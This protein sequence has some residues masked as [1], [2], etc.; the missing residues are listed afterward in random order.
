MQW[1]PQSQA[2]YGRY[3]SVEERLL[4]SD[5]KKHWLTNC[6]QTPPQV[7]SQPHPMRQPWVQPSP[8]A[9]SYTT[10][11]QRPAAATAT[12]G[13]KQYR[14]N[15]APTLRWALNATKEAISPALS[16]ISAVVRSGSVMQDII[17]SQSNHAGGDALTSKLWPIPELVVR[18]SRLSTGDSMRHMLFCRCPSPSFTGVDD[19]DVNSADPR[20][21]VEFHQFEAPFY[22][23]ASKGRVD[24]LCRSLIINGGT[25]VDLINYENTDTEGAATEWSTRQQLEGHNTMLLTSA[26]LNLFPHTASCPPAVAHPYFFIGTA[27]G[28][29]VVGKEL[30]ERAVSFDIPDLKG[31]T[32]A[33]SAAGAP[34]SG[35]VGSKG[36]TFPFYPWD[37]VTY[38]EKPKR[39][40]RLTKVTTLYGHPRGPVS[41]VVATPQ[42]D[43]LVSTAGGASGAGEVFVWDTARLML[44]RVIQLAGHSLVG[45]GPSLSYFFSDHLN[46]LPV[47]DASTSEDEAEEEL[48]PLEEIEDQPPAAPPVG[49]SDVITSEGSVAPV[50][51]GESANHEKDGKAADTL[52]SASADAI[53]AFE[54]SSSAGIEIEPRARKAITL[55]N[56]EVFTSK[57]RF[58][59]R[60]T[61]QLEL[62][63]QQ[64]Y[65]SA[66]WNSPLSDSPLLQTALS[67][68]SSLFFQPRS[69]RVV[70]AVNEATGDIVAAV[71][72]VQVVEQ[73]RPELMHGPPQL[74]H[75]LA[76]FSINGHPIAKIPADPPVHKQHKADNEVVCAPVT[77]AALTAATNGGDDK[78]H[79]ISPSH[80]PTTPNVVS[81]MNQTHRPSYELHDSI[82]A[83]LFVGNVVFAGFQDGVVG[84][85]CGKTLVPFGR[86]P[87]DNGEATNV[88]AVANAI[89]IGGVGGIGNT[90]NDPAARSGVNFASANCDP[91][92]SNMTDLA[93]SLAGGSGLSMLENVMPLPNVTGTTT[94][95]SGTQQGVGGVS[96]GA[97]GAGGGQHQQSKQHQGMD[98]VCP[99]VT[100]LSLNPWGTALLAV[101]VDG[102]VAHYTVN[103]NVLQSPI[104]NNQAAAVPTTSVSGISGGGIGNSGSNEHHHADTQQ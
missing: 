17:D 36:S 48:S 54:E 34:T 38:E 2:P 96:V 94:V 57:Q 5:Q 20:D 31:G 84:C 104:P 45:F 23:S 72:Y 64:Y 74:R 30:W 18:I 9:I 12:S 83:L 75:E 71:T 8:L 44:T 55:K 59:R 70:T 99:T 4:Q 65:L 40:L 22:V 79:S 28:A 63:R 26:G 50:V 32:A 95:V 81:L 68:S 16:L 41:S 98:E 97:P 27:S 15:P 11:G 3:A 78:S 39:F 85:F 91:S 69:V 6:G 49:D 73:N 43:M 61:R 90:E 62:Q 14:T 37:G 58:Q 1:H 101:S 10:A 19:D 100:R 86:L 24:T 47:S 80:H 103:A 66:Q 25:R 7:F 29:I 89:R 87:K 21:P 33:P 102:R 77:T 93:L 60:R 56:S 76:L 67:T 92:G 42:W 35:H 88:T 52:K 53:D 13:T 51:A 82:T 46:N